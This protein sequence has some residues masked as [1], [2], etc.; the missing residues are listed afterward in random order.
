[1]NMLVRRMWNAWIREVIKLCEEI[2]WPTK[3]EDGSIDPRFVQLVVILQSKIDPQFRH[4]GNQE[5]LRA[6]IERARKI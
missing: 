1:M 2:K 3:L 6:A 4:P 5:E